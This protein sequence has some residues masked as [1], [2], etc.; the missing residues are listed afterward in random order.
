MAPHR[1]GSTRAKRRAPSSCRSRW[2]GADGTTDLGTLIQGLQWAVDNQA[3]YN[4]KVLN[5]SLGFQAGESTVINPLD[6]AVEAA[7]NSGITVVASAG[8]AGPF[9]GTI[10]SPGDDPLVIT[11]GRAGRHGHAVGRRRRDDRLQ[12]RR[13]DLT[14]GWVKPDLVTSGRSVVSLAAPGST[15]YNEL[16]LGPDRHRRTSSARAPRSAPPSPAGRRPWSWPT[17]L[18][19]PRTR[20]RPGCSA[21]PTLARSAIPSSTATGHSTPTPRPP[22]AR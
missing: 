6:Q 15:I 17:T 16:P 3:A 2:P 5:I 18:V 8:N 21:R 20:S 9:N 12:Q 19:S 14:D 10:L 11:V 4:I 13:A 7:W 22:R 1:T